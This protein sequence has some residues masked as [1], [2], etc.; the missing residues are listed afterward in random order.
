MHHKQSQKNTLSILQM[1]T[2]KLQNWL[3]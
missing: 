3:T 1:I 2:H